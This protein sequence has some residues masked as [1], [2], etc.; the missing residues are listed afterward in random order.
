MAEGERDVARREADEAQK[1]SEEWIAELQA[2]RRRKET[3]IADLH[4][5]TEYAVVRET[6]LLEQHKNEAEKHRVAAAALEL[7][8]SEVVSLQ[9]DLCTEQ[10]KRAAAQQQGEAAA[11]ELVRLQCQV[12]EFESMLS[13]ANKRVAWERE[14]GDGARA[15]TALMEASWTLERVC[16]EVLVMEERRLR[17]QAAS[18]V[19][20]ANCDAASIR[21]TSVVFEANLTVQ[22]VLNAVD[23]AI[24]SEKLQLAAAERDEAVAKASAS[25]AR[26]E[27]SEIDE[28]MHVNC[29]YFALG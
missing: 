19:A 16:F 28:L 14:Q 23:Q 27:Q 8:R 5:K 10:N 2:E 6:N 12:A 21:Q 3:S 9:S 18:A 15:E 20:I 25:V 29:L 1:T 17:E 13:T 7:S 22:T 11:A 26:A 4:A 24:L